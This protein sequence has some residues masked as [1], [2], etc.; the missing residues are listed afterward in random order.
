MQLKKKKNPNLGLGKQDDRGG[1][2]SP[3]SVPAL[4]PA[5][6]LDPV[7]SRQQGHLSCREDRLGG[8]ARATAPLPCCVLHSAPL[9][10]GSCL[11]WT[12]RPPCVPQGTRGKIPRP[13]QKPLGKR[14]VAVS[15]RRMRKGY[16]EPA[17]LGTETT[18]TGKVG[19]LLLKDSALW[20]SKSTHRCPWCAGTRCLVGSEMH[21]ARGSAAP[22]P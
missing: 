4:L 19:L 2:E 16:R 21:G 10:L 11:P 8:W 9:H 18:R 22:T 5:F 6:S 7:S 13:S 3:C 12:L 20:G 17:L 15:I 1:A 14:S